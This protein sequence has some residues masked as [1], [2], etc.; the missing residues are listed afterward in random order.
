MCECVFRLRARTRSNQVSITGGLNIA[1]ACKTVLFAP[2]S[3]A[4]HQLHG[5]F[6]CKVRLVQRLPSAFYGHGR[7]AIDWK[8]AKSW[9]VQVQSLWSKLAGSSNGQ[10]SCGVWPDAIIS[11]SPRETTKQPARMLRWPGHTLSM[12][13]NGLGAIR[14]FTWHRVC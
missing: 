10:V 6:A 4:R 2:A 1:N 7:D 9:L 8:C 14:M 3:R 11:K 12:C 13:A 5:E